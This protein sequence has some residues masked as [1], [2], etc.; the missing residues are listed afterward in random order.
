M[1]EPGNNLEDWLKRVQ[2]ARS[3]EDIFAI[4]NEFK[5]L[6]WTDE[7]RASMSHAYMRV[8]ENTKD[9][10]KDQKSGAEEKQA[11]DG[12]VWYEKM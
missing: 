7:Q 6:D 5:A 4:L 11:A 10:A 12:P 9:S 3:R 8:L 2:N 1:G